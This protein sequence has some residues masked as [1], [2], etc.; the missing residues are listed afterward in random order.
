MDLLKR[1]GLSLMVSMKK[2]F[3]FT[4]KEASIVTLTRMLMR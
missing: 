2:N 4:I 1:V 3:I